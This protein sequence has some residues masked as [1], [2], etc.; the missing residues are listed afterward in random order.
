MPYNNEILGFMPEHELKV[1]ESLALQVPLNG[2]IVEVGSYMGRTAVCFAMTAPTSTIY[3]IDNFYEFPWTSDLIVTDD[4]AEKLKIPKFGSTY[5]ISEEFHKNT[6]DFHNIIP[7]KGH[8]PNIE[9]D[10]NNIDL[11]FI[12]AAH[13][14]PN[15][16]DIITFLLPKV[17]HNG[18]I[19]GH[20]YGHQYPDV[21]QNVNRLEQLLNKQ[22]TLYFKTSLWSFKLDYIV[23][24]DM[25]RAYRD[26][27]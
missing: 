7:I 25:A 5:V 20:D 3:C 2:T 14:N 11:L 26:Q 19:C 22:R 27:P 8:C 23:T 16:W 10:V 15:D 9:F 18:I 13:I 17:K 24:E 4:D 1:V 6:K 21:V 12:D